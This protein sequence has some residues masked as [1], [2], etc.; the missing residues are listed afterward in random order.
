MVIKIPICIRDIERKAINMEYSSME[1]YKAD[2]D[3]MFKNCIM[4]NI[5]IEG[6]WFRD[7]AQRQQNIWK[8]NI[9]SPAKV[10]HEREMTKRR[11][12]LR[13]AGLALAGAEASVKTTTAKEN[14][15]KNEK[16]RKH[17]IIL[18]QQKRAKL[19]S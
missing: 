14:K 11:E 12:K 5:G 7:E 6:K 13:N 8:D 19:A 17:E 2:V 9:W 18:A 10:A 1:E 3:L 4:Y 15:E 16:K